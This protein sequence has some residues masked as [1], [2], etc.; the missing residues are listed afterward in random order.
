[1]LISLLGHPIE[2]DLSRLPE[3]ATEAV[4]RLWEQSAIS[5]ATAEK[6]YRI[7][8]PDFNGDREST[9]IHLSTLEPSY[10]YEISQALTRRAITGATGELF[11]F[12]AAALSPEDMHD[13]DGRRLAIGISAP[14][15]TGKTTFCQ[16]LAGSF[17]YVTDETLAINSDSLRVHPYPKPLSLVRDGEA[18]RFKE[19]VPLAELGL[20]PVHADEETTLAALVLAERVDEGNELVPTSLIEAMNFAIA[21]SSAFYE[22]A[23]PMRRLA[24]L[25]SMAGGP[26]LLRFSDQAQCGDLLRSL[27]SMQSDDAGPDAVWWRHLPGVPGPGRHPLQSRE[28]NGEEVELAAEARYERAPWYDGIEAEDGLMLLFDRTPVTLAG[29]GAA[30]WLSLDEARSFEEVLH[31]VV[32]KLGEHP[33]S[34]AIVREALTELRSQGVVMLE[35]AATRVG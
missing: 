35:G 32:E 21:Q 16:R 25:L 8:P 18:G 13:A 6:T 15:G 23:E 34:E 24:T 33:E 5:E 14:S 30:V 20:T 7:L 28:V 9:D 31:A 2:L 19:D 11:M 1:M 10:T 29:A 12:H 3:N 4:E 17:S 22:L 27:V 26:W